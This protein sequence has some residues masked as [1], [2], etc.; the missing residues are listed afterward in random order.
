MSEILTWDIYNIISDSSL[1]GVRF[2][3]RLRKLALHRNITLLAENA[4]DENNIV[5]FA[6]ISG[7]DIDHIEELI[8]S[9][10]PNTRIEIKLSGIKNP[11]LSKIK[12]NFEER[13]T[14]VQLDN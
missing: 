4:T 13:Y 11:V 5:R 7:S 14:E 6:V 12:V 2:R 10:V 9:L 8:K 1:Q 3:G